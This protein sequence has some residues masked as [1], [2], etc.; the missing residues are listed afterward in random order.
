MALTLYI[1]V[2]LTPNED[3]EDKIL[4][5]KKPFNAFPDFFPSVY[6]FDRFSSATHNTL[7]S[8]WNDR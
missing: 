6:G 1:S 8:K 2:Y 7:K 3:F 4:N 5:T